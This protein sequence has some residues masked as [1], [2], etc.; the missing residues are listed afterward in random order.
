MTS[1]VS[2]STSIIPSSPLAECPVL[3]NPDNGIVA[4]T[5]NLRGD[6]ATYS[7]NAGYELV[8]EPLRVCDEQ[9]E[10]SGTAPTCRL[11]NLTTTLTDVILSIDSSLMPVIFLLTSF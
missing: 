5:G 1:P 10:W 9:G 3:V 11:G 2:R 7:C 8:G 6:M 4:V